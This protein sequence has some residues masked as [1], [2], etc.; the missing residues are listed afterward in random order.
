MK[1]LSLLLILPLWMSLCSRACAQGQNATYKQEQYYGPATFNTPAIA[2]KTNLLYDITTSFHLGMEVKTTM[3]QTLEIAAGYNPWTFS[4][5]RKWK[6]LLIQPE[7]R[8]WL[9]EAFHGHYLGV[10][11]HYAY[12]NIG[13]LPMKGTMKTSRYEG[14]LLGTGFTYG[15]QWMLSPRW[16]VEANIGVGYAFLEYEKYPC[17]RCSEKIKDGNRHYLGITKA[18]VSLVYIIK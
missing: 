12:Y 11:A 2:L 15:Y 5:N 3:K 17:Q 6:H 4:R 9:C 1:K 18:A 16:S 14:W 7:Y 8:F 10:H 13:R